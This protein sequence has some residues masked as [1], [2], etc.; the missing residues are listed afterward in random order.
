MPTPIPRR[1]AAIA[2]IG[3]ALLFSCQDSVAPNDSKSTATKLVFDPPPLADSAYMPD[4]ILAHVG[5]T[6][7][8]NTWNR[9]TPLTFHLE[10]NLP[11]PLASMETLQVNFLKWGM[12]SI[13]L[14][15][16]G[17]CDASSWKVDHD[18]V[19]EHLQRLMDSTPS[20]PRTRAGLISLY[21]KA[22]ISGDSLL[23]LFPAKIPVGISRDSVQDQILLQ[24]QKN[25][26]SLAAILDSVK[27]LP[28]RNIDSL[29]ALYLDLIS[30]KS[31]TT[32]D[33]SRLF[34]GA[35]KLFRLP[36]L[37]VRN[38]QKDSAQY[39]ARWVVSG[40]SAPFTVLIDG[41]AA[42][43]D[44][45]IYARTVPVSFGTNSVD[46][47]VSDRTGAKAYDTITVVRDD[48]APALAR[49]LPVDTAAVVFDSTSLVFAWNAS[50]VSGVKSVTIGGK[51]ATRT[52]SVW[53]VRLDLV[54]GT[55]RFVAIAEDSLGNPA[56]DTVK[57]RRLADTQG[58]TIAAIEGVGA[59]QVNY[60]S[61]SAPVAWMVAD[62]GGVKSVAIAGNP[63]SGFSGRYQ[64]II[65]LKPGQ[66]SVVIEAIDS[67]GNIRRDSVS[68]ERHRAMAI[69]VAAA[70]EA[71]VALKQDGS[72]SVWGGDLATTAQPV[73]MGATVSVS[74]GLGHILALTTAGTVVAWG[75][76]AHDVLKIP[77]QLSGVVAVAAGSTHSLALKRD[78]TVVGWGD[79]AKGQCS[80][81]YGL[82]DVV[83]IAAGYELSV[84][85]K[86][87]GTVWAWGDS[88]LKQT[89]VP[90]GITTAKSISA[91][92]GH[93]VV[94]LTDGTIKAWGDNAKGQISVPAN[95]PKVVQ[96]AA[97]G[98][99]TLA[100]LADSTV[101]GWGDNGAG[102]TT[103]P[104]G[105]K[106]VIAISAGY[107][108]S[109]A[110]LKDGTI[111]VWGDN[112]AAQ[113]TAPATLAKY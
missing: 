105:L 37:A 19:A 67:A 109:A 65:A 100:L 13:T 85:L 44:G 112:S 25:A 94:L 111:V 99:H 55:N 38:V 104:A 107:A 45:S 11:K 1:L 39:Q 14:R 4:Q 20:Q 60:D 34:P 68:V 29:R 18:S 106:N 7:A 75:A 91:G 43:A 70:G 49:T 66:N 113:A 28:T 84:A 86:K 96:V 58:P 12:R 47:S 69:Q 110:L 62:V 59:R 77:N 9:L 78:G 24:A 16:T 8:T 42:E 6:T 50:D 10:V 17:A 72:I 30:R 81:P 103:V 27:W 76:S 46:I 57:I 74:A 90:T 52:G 33:S 53:L 64:T 95:L 48:G 80:M 73:D 5:T 15:C 35:P 21:A 88:S 22:L 63:V 108:H 82:S 93:A 101:I 54:P 83:A 3:S 40:G 87:D 41:V 61:A 31:L 102:Q 26:S 79:T 71:T 56:S 51:P 32:S 92:F 23:K 2:L 89:S 98:G 97:G 36:D